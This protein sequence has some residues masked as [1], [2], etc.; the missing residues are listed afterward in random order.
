MADAEGR[1]PE[2]RCRRFAH[3]H[4]SRTAPH[5]GGQR[6]LGIRTVDSNN[7]GAINARRRR[8]GETTIPGSGE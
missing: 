4:V 2:H 3:R 1:S 6:H 8:V 7:L 5:L